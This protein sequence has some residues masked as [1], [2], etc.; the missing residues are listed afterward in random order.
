MRKDLLGT[1][2]YNNDKLWPPKEGYIVQILNNLQNI[3]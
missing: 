1:M 2:V 3:R